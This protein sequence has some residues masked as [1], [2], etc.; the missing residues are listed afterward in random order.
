MISCPECRW[1]EFTELDDTSRP[2]PDNTPLE[3]RER[4]PLLKS[5]AEYYLDRGEYAGYALQLLLGNKR[6]PFTDVGT[7]TQE[8]RLDEGLALLERTSGGDV[9]SLLAAVLIA[10]PGLRTSVMEAVG[11]RVQETKPLLTV[12]RA[13]HLFI[14]NGLTE[15]QW[16]N[17][18]DYFPNHDGTASRLPPLA[19]LKRYIEDNLLEKNIATPSGRGHRVPDVRAT[20]QRRVL[21]ELRAAGCDGFEEKQDKIA[22]EIELTGDGF[23]TERSHGRNLKTFS[24]SF[25]VTKVKN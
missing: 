1:Q 21:Q 15:T 20:I 12:E 10:H 6:K 5:L 11:V 23:S 18:R 17:M 14:K 7:R 2:E 13:V 3:P 22:V 9:A 16:K 24:M 25:L 19:Q 8:T 4:I